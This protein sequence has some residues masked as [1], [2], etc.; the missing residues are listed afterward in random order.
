MSSQE[1]LR[2]AVNAPLSHLFDYLPPAGNDGLL[3]SALSP[4]ARVLVP[5]GRQQV[6][7][8][9][10]EQ[11]EHSDLPRNKLR[12]AVAL[13]DDNPLFGEH[14]LWLLRFARVRVNGL[15]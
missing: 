1:I 3:P 10:L 2:V 7:G 9:I 8:L 15:R 5:F 6:V 11:A 4:G 14:D 13:L 12:R